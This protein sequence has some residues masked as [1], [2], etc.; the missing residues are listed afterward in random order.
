MNFKTGNLVNTER[1]FIRNEE[2]LF[3]TAQVF[4]KMIGECE[5]SLEI[6]Q[7]FADG[8]KYRQIVDVDDR[9]YYEPDMAYAGPYEIADIESEY[10]KYTKSIKNGDI[11]VVTEITKSEYYDKLNEAKHSATYKERSSYT[12]IQNGIQFHLDIDY[13]PDINQGIS[14]LDI[15]EISGYNLDKFICP[16]YLTEVTGNPKYSAVSIYENGGV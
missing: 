15:F 10:T 2:W 5:A 1:K 7:F 3:D 9:K 16:P 6:S 11:T 14:N 12:F 4:R 8:V 13:F